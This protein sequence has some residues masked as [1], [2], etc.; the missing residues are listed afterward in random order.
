MRLEAS[1]RL[2]KD[3]LRL[4]EANLHNDYDFFEDA[5]KTLVYTKFQVVLRIL[6]GCFKVTEDNI[7]GCLEI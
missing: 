4:L 6:S 1:L 2:F 5:F 7:R 3:Q